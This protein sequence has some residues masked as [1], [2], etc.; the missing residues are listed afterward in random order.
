MRTIAIC[1]IVFFL[2]GWPAVWS[3]QAAVDSSNFESYFDKILIKLNV[4]SQ[5]DQYSLREKNATGLALRANTEYKVF[6]SL[7]YEFI[8][9]SYGFSP[10]LFYANNDDDLKGHS[11]FTNY[12]FQFFPGQWLQTVSY[13]RTKG[14]YV[15]NSGDFLPGWQ[16]GVDAYLQVPN[17]KS[18]Q[19]A[20]S[21]FYVINRD[22]S[23]KNL[24]YQT[25][26]QKR[27]AGSFVPSLF[28][29][30]TR[31]SFDLMG[32]QALQKDVNL[33]LGLGYY[34]TFIMGKHFFAA[35]SLVPSIGVRF[36]GYRSD[37]GGSVSNEHNTYFTRFLEGGL[38][39]GF[40]AKRWVAGGGFSFNVNWYNE[41]VGRVVENDKL[42][43]IVYVGYRFGTPR[44]ITDLYNAVNKHLP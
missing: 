15:E 28:Y 10:R 16:K 1:Y 4:S 42:F 14:Y 34:Y 21:T 41:G 13:D 12:K 3:Q 25:Q 30:Y 9:F 36:S 38:K 26:W 19:W 11:S 32:V 29:D 44:F 18:V 43:G 23:F 33:R 5:S 37:E 22:F 8:G 17:L 35:P 6:L 20:G 31:Y 2:A 39:V 27:S 40:N 24:I 7:D